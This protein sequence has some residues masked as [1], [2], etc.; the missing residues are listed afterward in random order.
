M[1][2]MLY[3]HP[4]PHKIHGGEF[5]YVIVDDDQVDEALKKGWSKTT[6]EALEK[7]LPKKRK[8]RA[9]KE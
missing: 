8:P 4:G 9:K 1:K 2:T 6:P 5:D 7:A 3:A